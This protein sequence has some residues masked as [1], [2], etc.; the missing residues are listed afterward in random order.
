LGPY[1]TVASATTQNASDTQPPTAPGA[2]ILSVVSNT[3]INLTWAGATDNVGVTSYFVE[4]CTG[5]G[6]S[7]FAPVG[8]PATASLND[9]GLTPSTSYTYRVRATDAAGNL[10]AYS[11]TATAATFDSPTITLVQHNSIDAGTT[12]L[13]SLAFGA[14]TIAG[15]WI[16]V[17][18][19][20]G[21]TGQT[22]TVTDTAGNTYQKAVQLNETTDNT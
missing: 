1:S 3:Q 16:A 9:T 18:I 4:R 6:C 7:T 20:A 15:N 11:S 22:F 17:V 5:A 19:R 2:P 12:K 21:R 8:S 13:S 10:G 14:N